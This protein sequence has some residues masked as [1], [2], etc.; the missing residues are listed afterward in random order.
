M[1]EPC[2]VLGSHPAVLGRDRQCDVAFD[3]PSVADHHACVWSDDS[4]ITVACLGAGVPIELDGRRVQKR[5]QARDGAWLQL[6]RA[7]P[8]RVR[9]A[10]RSEAPIR[11]C[12]RNA[13]ELWVRFDHTLSRPRMTLQLG[14]TADVAF[15]L[16]SRLAWDAAKG[17]QEEG[18]WL[19]DGELSDNLWGRGRCARGSLNVA[20]HR[21]RG[22]LEAH[23]FDRRIV[24]KA[25][26]RTRLRPALVAVHA[27]YLR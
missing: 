21:L 13:P 26:G 24:Q 17:V 4:S 14:R 2:L 25:G 7:R 16:A 11:L 6:G 27:A 8:F 20:V 5:A 9:T 19:D 18:G 23:G 1:T 15:L 12:L 3:D 22:E 10:P